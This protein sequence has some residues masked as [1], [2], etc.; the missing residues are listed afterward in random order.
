MR[1]LSPR[2][3]CSMGDLEPGSVPLRSPMALLTLAALSI[4]FAATSC[5]YRVVG[6]ANTIPD[7]IQR[8]S[9]KTFQ[10]ATTEYKIEQHL[11]RWVVREFISRT[12]YQIVHD[13]RNADAT[14]EGTVLN[15]L[16]FP[17]IFRSRQRTRHQ[18]FDHYA[19]SYCFARP[20]DGRGTLRESAV[21]APGKVRSQHVS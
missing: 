10:N 9:V 18:C 14:L 8:V 1:R 16:V 20:A 2:P 7:H 11:T 3:A 13:D 4:A 19:G 17:V 5:G 6:S 12:R 15:F 21:R